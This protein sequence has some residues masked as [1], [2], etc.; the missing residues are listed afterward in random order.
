MLLLDLKDLKAML[1]TRVKTPTAIRS[2]RQHRQAPVGAIQRAVAV[3]RTG[4]DAFSENALEITTGSE[5]RKA[6]A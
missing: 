3:W 4:G 2:L 1:S 5:V 6:A